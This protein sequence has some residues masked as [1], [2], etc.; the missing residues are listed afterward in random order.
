MEQLRAIGLTRNIPYPNEYILALEGELSQYALNEEKVLTLKGCWRETAF[1]SAPNSPLDLEI[2][3]GNGDHFAHQGF[4]QPHRYLVGLELKYKPLIQS[5]RR[6]LRKGCRNIRMARY[7]AQFLHHIFEE[8]E[9]NNVY[10]HFPDPWPK[11]RQSKNRLIQPSFLKNLFQIQREGSFVEFKTDSRPY[12][13]QALEFFEDSPYTVDLLSYDLYDS[14]LVKTNFQTHFE[15]IFTSKHLPI[16]YA[17]LICEKSESGKQT[18]SQ[19][20]KG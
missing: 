10:I 12:F 18:A 6:A 9:L 3:T 16:Y 5:I 13:D 20:A 17:K 19:I 2:G 7:P 1:S 15:K 11:R 4:R 8:N 14:P